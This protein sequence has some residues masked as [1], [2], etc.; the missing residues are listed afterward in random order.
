MKER[1]GGRRYEGEWKR[2]FAE[3]E[4]EQTYLEEMRS[5]GQRREKKRKRRKAEYW[6][7]R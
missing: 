4:Q 1:E 3:I 2:G 6:K 5:E 7:Q